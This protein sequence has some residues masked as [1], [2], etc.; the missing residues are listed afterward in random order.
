M[1]CMVRVVLYLL[2]Y[3][4]GANGDGNRLSPNRLDSQVHAHMS[5]ILRA[6]EQLLLGISNLCAA[7]DNKLIA[8]HVNPHEIIRMSSQDHFD[9]SSAHRMTLERAGSDQ[10]CGYP[11]EFKD[12]GSIPILLYRSILHSEHHVHGGLAP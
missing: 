1:E 9:R 3:R 5:R 6:I 7:S 8:W 10:T 11:C 2:R 4:V 12:L